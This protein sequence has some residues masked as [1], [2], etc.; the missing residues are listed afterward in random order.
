MPLSCLTYLN[1]SKNLINDFHKLQPLQMIDNL[2]VFLADNPF[3]DGDGWKTKLKHYG[4]KILKES[5]VLDTS[6]KIKE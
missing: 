3:L 2:E 6:V 4:I 1:I 5:R